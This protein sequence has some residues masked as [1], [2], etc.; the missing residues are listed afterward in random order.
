MSNL[1]IS[2]LP[3]SSGLTGIEILPIVQS[4]VTVQATVQDVANLG[5]MAAGT[6]TGSTVR[7]NNG[8]SASG[9]YST[10]SGGG[11]VIDSCGTLVPVPNSAL[12]THSTVGGGRT[13][14]ANTENSTVG[15]GRN[16]TAGIR[17][18]VGF[19]YDLIY[20]GN[21][22][23]G[24]FSNIQPSSTLTTSGSDPTLL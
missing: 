21:T 24:T 16:N 19:A 14:K 5:I 6:G 17:G 10:V 1:S 18:M 22:L 13:N 20:T 3:S 7:I 9:N 2:Q 23:D 11:G 12:G 15:G 8:N 4:G